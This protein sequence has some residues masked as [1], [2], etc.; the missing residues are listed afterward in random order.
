MLVDWFTVGAQALNFVILVWLMRRF[1]YKPIL[2]A[3]DAREKRIA[4]RLADA[5]ATENA[6][7]QERD[8]LQHR[9]EELDQQRAGILKKATDDAAAERRRLLVEARSAADAVGAKRQETLRA[10]AEHLERALQRRAQQEVFAIARKALTELATTS[11]DERLVAVFTRRLRELDDPAKA[12]LAKALAAA[13]DTAI[14][15]SAFELPP[16][17]R[18]IVQNALKETFSAEVQVRFQTAPELVS[19][20]EL[21][22]DG[23]KLGWNIAEYLRSLQDGVDELLNDKVA[24]QVKAEPK[25]D[26]K[27]E[28]EP[29]ADATVD[30]G[31]EAKPTP[32]PKPERRPTSRP[33]ASS[34]TKPRAHSSE[35]KGR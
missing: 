22:A 19:G 29:E 21:V 17:Q 10:D 27:A 32:Q 8:E 30:P 14:V 23:H 13:P 24:A 28:H 33:E 34:P 31:P 5:T 16:D 7:H 35:T 3:I 12:G 15:R 18:A 4:E 6:A 11:L 20:I 9:N 2:H 26:A 25:L 1:L